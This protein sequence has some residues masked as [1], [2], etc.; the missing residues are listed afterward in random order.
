[1][2]YFH[3]LLLSVFISIISSFILKVMSPCICCYVFYPLSFSLCGNNLHVSL[4]YL[5]LF[6]SSL[7][8]YRS[9]FVC[10][11]FRLSCSV[12]PFLFLVFLISLHA[13]PDIGFGICLYVRTDT[14]VQPLFFLM[15]CFSLKKNAQNK[16]TAE[17]MTLWFWAQNLVNSI[18]ASW[19]TEW[20]YILILSVCEV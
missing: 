18:S 19:H 4:L 5:S 17:L 12:W 15:F 9:M 14:L 3:W 13:A 1:M 10:A 7:F 6:I 20:W 11:C 16:K 2:S 8:V